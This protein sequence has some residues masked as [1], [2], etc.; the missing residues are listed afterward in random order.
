MNELEPIWKKKW[1]DNGIYE[2]IML[3]KVTAIAKPEL[4]T[5]TLLFYN[6]RTNTFDFRMGPMSLTVLDMAQ[7][8]ELRPLGKNIDITHDWSLLS[9]PTAEIS[10]ASNSVTRLEYTPSTFKSY[11]RSFVS[12][13][14]FMKKTFSRPLATA[15]RDKKHMYF[16]LY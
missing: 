6:N 3:S 8:F 12:F 2:L 5:T 1:M 16:L 13:I 10:G 15:N 4:L 9:C 11:S 7:V 14:P